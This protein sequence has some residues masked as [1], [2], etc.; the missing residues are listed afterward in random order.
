MLVTESVRERPRCAMFSG[1]IPD[2]FPKESFPSKT[3][4]TPKRKIKQ[5][6]ELGLCVPEVQER[7]K[8]CVGFPVVMI[9]SDEERNK[10]QANASVKD[11]RSSCIMCGEKTKFF[12]QRLFF[13]VLHGIN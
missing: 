9:C 11:E 12:L 10:R 4:Q 5:K 2:P 1:I 6:L 8:K 13:L 7:A 3:H